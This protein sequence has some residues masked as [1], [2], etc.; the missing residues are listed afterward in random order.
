MTTSWERSILFFLMLI[1]LV[2]GAAFALLTPDWQVPDEPAHFN[3]VRQVATSRRCC[4]QIEPGDWDQAYLSQLTTAHFPGSLLGQF[5]SIQYEDHQPPLYYQ[6]TS[7]IFNLSSDRSVQLRL[8]RLV[9]VLFGAGVVY[10]AYALSKAILPERPGVALGAAA[11]VAFLPQHMAMIASVNN[12]SLNELLIG[13]TLLVT[14]RYVLGQYEANIKLLPRLGLIVAL[15]LSA[16]LVTH[17]VPTTVGALFVGLLTVA[18][19]GYLSTKGE[20]HWQIWVIGIIVGLIFNTKA[21]GYFLAGVV[22][23]VLILHWWQRRNRSQI[24]VTWRSL[25]K[26][27]AYFLIPALILGVLWW[28]RNLGVYGF[29][30]FLGLG[31]HNSVVADQLRTADK[32]AAVGYNSYLSESI[33]TAFDSFWGQF[34]W[35]AL[36]LQDWMYTI[37]LGL[38]LFV[39]A[40]LIIAFLQPHRRAGEETPSRAPVW[41]MLWLT[42]GLTLL[43]FIY[44]NSEFVQPQGRYLYTALIPIGLLAALGIDAWRRWLLPHV[45]AIR[46]LSLGVYS[47]LAPFDL[48]LLLYVIR[49]LLAP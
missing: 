18:L 2:I 45:I 9:S 32:I 36:P 13:L 24:A 44:Y 17:R 16:L 31:A 10:C 7:V 47:L 43:A 30:D 39:I 37:A 41:L 42:I 25:G 21:T 46:W 4:P 22:P 27:L 14:A 3:Y 12:D 35:M 23:L 40:G 34:G 28:Q 1:Y 26:Q 15:V 6:I 11:F 8:I 49:P 48:Y 38:T 20:K 19:Q 5:N 33:R 29:P